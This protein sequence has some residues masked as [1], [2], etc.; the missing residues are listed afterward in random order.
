MHAGL[1]NGSSAPGNDS[2][3][4]EDVEM[5]DNEGVDPEEIE[6]RQEEAQRRHDEIK[7]QREAAEKQ[8]QEV[9]SKL[10]EMEAERAKIEAMLAKRTNK[11][12][13]VD[14]GSP[15]TNGGEE[16]EQTKALKAQLAQ[17]E[18]EAKS[19]GI[20]PDAPSTNGHSSYPVHRGRG[21]YRGR[22]RGRG[23]GYYRGSTGAWAGTGGRGGGAVM[24]LDNRPKTVAVSFSSGTYDEYDEAIRQF[25]LFNSLDSATISKHPGQ[26]D[27]A[28]VAF[29]QRYE[30]ENF[31]AAIANSELPHVGKV[32]LSWYKAD[33]KPHETTNGAPETDESKVVINDVSDKPSSDV[34]EA[35]MVFDTVEED[36]DR[37]G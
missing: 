11:A 35:E 27:M 33:S 36:L 24:R 23:R 2:S 9:N 26:D 1:A 3:G 8:R 18:A 31:M 29:N 12:S 14:A 32:E 17:L 19:L 15:Q 37:W 21:S 5:G 34:A 25:L 13:S 30:G 20:D 28:L 10:K 4:V 7:K 6:R 16:N 22:A